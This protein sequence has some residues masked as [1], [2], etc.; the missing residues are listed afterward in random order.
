MKKI[1]LVMAVLALI[2][3]SCEKEMDLEPLVDESAMITDTPDEVV[4][5][6]YIVLLEGGIT[7]LKS[8][9][10]DVE[11]RNEVVV[12]EAN[13]AL[14]RAGIRGKE[15]DHVY[16]SALRGFAIGLSDEEARKLAEQPE[17]R[18]VWEDRIITLGKRKPVP[19]EPPPDESVPAGIARVGGG[20]TYEGANVAWIIDTGIDLDHPDLN[21]DAS[22][23]DVWD[24][25]ATTPDDDNGHGTHCAGIVAAKKNNDIG[26]VG[27]AAGA[28]V[29]PVKVLDRRGSGTS[30]NI[31]AGVDFVAAN[32]AKGDVA[33][34]SLGG[35]VNELLDEAVENLG[36]SGVLVALAA[37][38]E[39]EDANNHSPAR[40]NGP[41]LYTVSAMD[42]YDNWASFSNYGNPPVD[43]CA[44]GVSIYSTYKSGGYATMSGTSMAAPHVCGL[45]LLK[46]GEYLNTN[47]TVNGDDDGNPDLIA[48]IDDYDGVADPIAHK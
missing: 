28:T 16:S 1:F 39:S 34:L 3:Y 38:N 12:D 13:E 27:V 21:V 42:K 29:I 20:D 24:R 40:A 32:A 2:L 46:T 15:F 19:T 43:Y 17:V 6:K 41:N 10:A 26:V 5:G 22:R 4:K 33:N 35:G 7:T 11:A 18:G 48:V 45:L 37:G 9:Y 30:S 14:S 36:A 8:A 31:I 47:G 25:R 44:P 23:G